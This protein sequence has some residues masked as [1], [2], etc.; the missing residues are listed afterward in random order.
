M[1][2][3]IGKCGPMQLDVKSYTVASPVWRGGRGV[4]G[5]QTCAIL[6][7][8]EQRNRAMANFYFTYVICQS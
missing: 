4:T 8:P 3:N 5:E 2:E 7:G 6:K 1:F